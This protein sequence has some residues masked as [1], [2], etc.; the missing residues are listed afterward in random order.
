MRPEDR[1]EDLFYKIALTFIPNVGGSIGRTLLERFGTARDIFSAPV[2]ELLRVNGISENRVKAFRDPEVFEKA[3]KELKFVDSH[4]ICILMSDD[5]A[6]PSRLTNCSDAPLLLYYHGNAN[7]NTSKAIAIVGT[8]KHTDYGMRLCEDL[9]EGLQSQEDI[10][11]ISGLALGIDSIAHKK[12]VSMGMPTVGVMG[13]GLDTVYPASNKKLAKDMLQNGGL[14]T[15]F[16]SGTIPERGNF[17]ARNRVVAGMSDVTVVVESDISGGALITA[18]MASSYNREVAA[19][20]GRVHDS[21]SSGCNEI[22]RTNLAAM[23]TNADD[24]LDLMNWRDDKK[25]KVVQKQLMLTFSPDEQRIVDL[26]QTK[27]SVHSDELYHYTGLN[28]SQLA[29]TLLQLEMQGVI[30]ALPGKN[31]RIN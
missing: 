2:K 4:N 13:N 27:D 24:L 12:A 10:L 21:K 22:I 30:K 1:N 25:K 29:A 23:I 28:S 5:A 6:Y 3:E 31:Y 9:V 15:E 19:F 20:P 17:P 16:I 11:I 7:L 14:L 18:H 8:R 26:L